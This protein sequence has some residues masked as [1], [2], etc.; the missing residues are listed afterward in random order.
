MLQQT[1]QT[2][3]VLQVV[4]VEIFEKMKSFVI[5]F[6]LLLSLNL[7]QALPSPDYTHTYAG[8]IH[9]TG[10]HVGGCENGSIPPYCCANRSPSPY[11]CANNSPSPYCCDNHSMRPNCS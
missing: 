7:I 4:K 6:A 9:I 2:N 3:L 11:C 10:N 5:I 8:H 1:S